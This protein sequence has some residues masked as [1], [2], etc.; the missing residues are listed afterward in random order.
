MYRACSKL[1]CGTEDHWSLLRDLTSIELFAN[2]EFYAFHPYIKEKLAIF[3]SENTAFSAT[4]SDDALAGGYDRTNPSTRTAAVMREAMRNATNNTFSSLLCMFSLSS[5]TGM[6][7]TTVYPEIIGKETK[8][9]KF[10]N[11]TISPRAAHTSISSKFVQDVQLILLW[12]T[13]GIAVLPGL[14]TSFKPNHFVPL[15]QVQQSEGNIKSKVKV[16]PKITDVL[17]S[18]RRDTTVSKGKHFRTLHG[19]H[20][21]CVL[22]LS[23][24]YKTNINGI[25]SL[26]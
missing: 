11:G 19:I 13:A 2:Q 14:D 10:L 26:F 5:V 7:I 3:C 16:Q 15:V 20:T 23:M 1:L 6:N 21:L 22:V 25:N 4:A 8:Y 17:K 18:A 9:S 24:F 12:S